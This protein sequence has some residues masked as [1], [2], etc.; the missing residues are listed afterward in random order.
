MPRIALYIPLIIIYLSGIVVLLDVF[1]DGLLDETAALLGLWVSIILA[2]ALL[3]GLGNILLVHLRRLRKG[4]TNTLYSGALLLSAIGVIGVGV[5][6]Q[7]TGQRDA[8]TNW[9]Y[10]YLY[11][12]LVT[13][14]FSLLAFLALLAAV[15]SLRI[16]TIE[17]FLLLVGALIVLL[18]Q[19]ALTPFAGITQISRW[20]QDYPVQGILRGVLIGAALG[21]V[22]ASLRYLLGVD[23]K[24]L[25]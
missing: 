2:F 21:A 23:N 6:G 15:K 9:I 10:Q 12:P 11:Q 7:V 13:A 19:V 3:L 8:Y 5:L 1:T 16:G 24:Y 25:R 20:F 17:S 4:G 18:G 22:A 14:F